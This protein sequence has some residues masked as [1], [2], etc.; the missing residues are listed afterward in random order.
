[1]QAGNGAGGCQL[2]V[3]P[4]WDPGLAPAAQ[5]VLS[6]GCPCSLAELPQQ[7]QGCS[8]GA[9]AACSGQG[10]CLSSAPEVGMCVTVPS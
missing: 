3:S 1:M 7:D 6:S 4:C 9:P 2:L 8:P 10:S 5:P